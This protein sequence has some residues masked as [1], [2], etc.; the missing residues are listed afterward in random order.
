MERP[1]VQCIHLH[2][3]L[4]KYKNDS[5]KEKIGMLIL[6]V[7]GNFYSQ[8]LKYAKQYNRINDL[9]II[10]PGGKYKYNPLNKPNLKPTVLANRIKDILL[11]FSPNN[12]E[13]YWLDKVEQL[14]TECIKF[15][16]L[17][18]DN[19]V[20]FEEI[21]NLINTPNYYLE[22]IEIL[23][24]LFLSQKLTKEDM[25]NL[26]S[27]LNFFEKEFL[28]LDSRTLSILKSETT[29]ITSCFLSDYEIYK[30]FN[31]T[32]E[33]ENFYGFKDLINTGKIVVLNMN[34][35][36]F[37]NV[38]KI[39]AAYLKL[40][41]QTEVLSRLS[42]QK[43]LR[44]VAFISDEYHEYVTNNDVDF[45]AQCREAKCINIL[46]TQSYSSLLNT[47]KN[48]T[49]LKVLIQNLVNKLWFRTDD[50]FTIEITQKQLGKEEKEKISTTI[51]EN[52]KE[53]YYNF[54][55]N[56]LNSTNSN[57]SE[58]INK[59]SQ[60]DFIYDTNFF[61]Q[62]LETFTCLSFLSNGNQILTPQKIRLIPYFISEERM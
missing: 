10:E 32:K 34:I 19:Y 27:S 38:S 61:T 13:S 5:I 47:L 44:K 39:I 31:P 29:R 18:N 12:S 15:C 57:I 51:S 7:K 59:Y 6:D 16:R 40:D 4:I 41:F 35:S 50:Y 23:R 24:N 54:F 30:T 53:T 21:H 25:Y 58:S 11:L 33:E 48:E 60:F 42:Y 45:Y 22:K 26:I 14:I 20:T 1:V 43:D 56:S 17:Y 8:V 36:E 9:I 55:T 37:K 62:K 52:A 2:G 3:Q 46:A 28:K 49:T